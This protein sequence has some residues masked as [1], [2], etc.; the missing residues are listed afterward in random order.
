MLHGWLLLADGFEVTEALGTLD[1]LRRTH[2]IDVKT[3]SISDAQAVLSSCG[4]SVLADRV[5]KEINPADGDFLI[6][7]G[8]KV[9]VDNLGASKIV[10]VM[11]LDYFQK[12]KGVFAICAAPSILGE[13][14]ILDGKKYTCFPGFQRGNGTYI[15]TGAI[16]DENVIT[17]HSM[18]Y[19]LDF[20]SEIIVYLLGEEALKRIEPGTK[21]L[22]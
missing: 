19:S 5:M 6:L 3:V 15:D 8:G 22:A 2:Q 17:G 18:A 13:L 7:P 21:G 14:G 10:R 9:G 4:V 1:L 11:A 20:G 16:R 12:G